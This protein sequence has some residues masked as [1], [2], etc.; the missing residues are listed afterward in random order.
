MALARPL[1]PDVLDDHGLIPALHS[2]V[3]VFSDQTGVLA[4][5]NSR[6]QMGSLTPEQQLVVY[7]VTQES[8]SNIAQHAGAEQVDVELSFIGRTMLRISDN[9]RGF[10]ASRDGGLGLSGMRERARLVGGQLSIWSGRLDRN[11]G[12]ADPAMTTQSEETID[13]HPRSRRSRDRSIQESSCCWS[14]RPICRS[15]PR[16]PTASRPSSRRWP[17]SPD[18]VHPRHRDAAQD[19]A[20]SG[21]RDP[22][23]FLGETR[24]LILSMHD[25][26]HYLFEAS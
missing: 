8:L 3:Q 11:K 21:S 2:Q 13:A 17:R 15:S 19:R 22:R 20:A 6:G 1:R 14:G 24:V 23:S 12:R 18:A 26:E 10:S 25:D 16:P 5:F 4:T 9:G 7:R